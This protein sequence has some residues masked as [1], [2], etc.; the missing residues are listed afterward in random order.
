M[1]QL[2]SRPIGG[3][4]SRMQHEFRTNHRPNLTA[5]VRT[6]AGLAFLAAAA[7]LY[8][9][10]RTTDAQ[11][12][13]DLAS[14]PESEVP[15]QPLAR[16]LE[17]PMQIVSTAREDKP[18][19]VVTLVDARPAAL[20]D[21][22]PV[23]WGELRE[24][25][26]EA[27]GA[28][29]LRE[30]ILERGLSELLLDRG[31]VI[32]DAAVAAERELFITSLNPDPDLAL[33]LLDEIRARQGLGT[34]RFR[35]LLWQNAALRALVR[36]RAEIT[37]EAVARMFELVHGPKRQARLI[38]VPNLAAVDTVSARLEA[39]EPFADVAVEVSTDPSAARGGL[40]EPMS[41]V[42]DTYPTA[43]REAIFQLEPLG[44]NEDL[45]PTSL[46]LTS[47]PILLDNGY[48]ILKLER[49]FAATRTELSEVR[50][51]MERLV[52]INQER[53]LM[54][55][56]ARNILLDANVTVIDAALHESWTR[57]RNN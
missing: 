54:D 27:A 45:R 26:T 57:S 21:T 19:A 9:C 43:V 20:V 53:V 28:E 29:A 31:I 35:K 32:D 11:R 34:T 2:T 17:S 23:T 7:L 25:V 14:S 52:R 5:I 47:M 6:A 12:Q 15:G 46:G 41:K 48:A 3:S 8:G 4:L 50:E 56:L 36:E 39:G 42:D 51:E 49:K 10:G 16:P 1:L 22:V 30:I 13:D 40:L 18:D 44:N 37:P 33:R 55:Q 24:S 38:I